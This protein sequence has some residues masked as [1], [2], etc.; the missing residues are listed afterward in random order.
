MALKATPIMSDRIILADIDRTIAKMEGDC[1][2]DERAW[3]QVRQATEG[4]FNWI[5]SMR[6]DDTI[7]WS[8]DTAEERRVNFREVMAAHVYLT[9]I[10]AGNILD[11]S[12][13]PIFTFKDGGDY[14]KLNMTFNQFKERYG[15]LNASVTSAIRK[16]VYTLNP[17]WDWTNEGEV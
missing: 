10:D 12:G 8:G 9:L 7:K 11:A 3:V 6:T 4:D 13:K 16:A 5:A 15:M 1:D 14:S 2:K 17:E